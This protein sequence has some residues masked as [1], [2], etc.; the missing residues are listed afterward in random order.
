MELEG[1]QIKNKDKNYQEN[2]RNYAKANF[3]KLK[4]YFGGYLDNNLWDLRHSGKLQ[5]F[6]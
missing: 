6:S 2:R 5:V 4:K 3:D 1:N